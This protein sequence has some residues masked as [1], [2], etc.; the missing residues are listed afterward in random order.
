M[1]IRELA[2]RGY[3]IEVAFSR[4]P[5]GV[6]MDDPPN[7]SRLDV[8]AFANE[9]ARL[10]GAPAYGCSCVVIDFEEERADPRHH[11]PR[12]KIIATLNVLLE[13]LSKAPTV[14]P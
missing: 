8:A 6:R 4:V 2:E 12:V 1:N 14:A 9:E 3:K 5:C 11:G 13:T 10:A 7:A